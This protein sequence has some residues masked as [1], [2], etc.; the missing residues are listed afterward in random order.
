MCP[1]HYFLHKLAPSSSDSEV[2][3]CGRK[4]NCDLLPEGLDEGLLRLRHSRDLRCLRFCTT[5]GAAVRRA[6]KSPGDSF[7]RGEDASSSK[8]ENVY[9]GAA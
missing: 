8:S 6:F 5:S 2:L 1:S 9:I 4:W 3:E 7:E